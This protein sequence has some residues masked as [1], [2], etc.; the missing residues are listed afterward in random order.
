MR[1]G[2]LFLLAI[3]V[4]HTQLVAQTS[5]QDSIVAKIRSEFEIGNIYD[6]EVLGLKALHT[7]GDLSKKHL[8]EIHK[9]LAF[10][11]VAMGERE[12]ALS[13]FLAMLEIDPSYKF[14]RQIISPKITEVFDL[15][16]EQF[17]Q[18]RK[19]LIKANHKSLE[20][21]R[22]TA[23]LRSLIFPGLGQLSKGEKTKGY[24]IMSGETFSILSL[25]FT[26][27][28]LSQT[29]N[30]YLKA[31][32]SA[33]IAEKYRI[34]NKYYRLRNFSLISTIGIYLYSYLDCLYTKQPTEKKSFSLSVSPDRLNLVFRF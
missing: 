27:Y 22:I 26:Q 33:E 19:E 3:I 4:F 13:E 6:A 15:A 25:G 18:K 8:F 7:P 5:V 34:Y 11:Y 20:S 14:D 31:T 16:Q 2:S 1:K 32:Y 28:K 30:D 9:Y 12:N 23:S 29:H 24:I 10:C 17:K 21:Q